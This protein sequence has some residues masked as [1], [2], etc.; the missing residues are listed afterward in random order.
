MD[1]I[2]YQE[3]WEAWIIKSF[4]EKGYAVTGRDCLKAL[5]YS[6]VWHGIEDMTLMFRRE[7]LDSFQDAFYIREELL[8]AGSTPD[9]CR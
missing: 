4:V 5:P 3:E 6:R 1:V 8:Y 9:L 2:Q 7:N